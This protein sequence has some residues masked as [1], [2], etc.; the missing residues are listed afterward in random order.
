[1][2]GIFNFF[3]RRAEP[4]VEPRNYSSVYLVLSGLLFLGTMWALVD[5]ISTR[6]PWKEFQESYFKLSEKKWHE[7]LDEATTGFD[8]ASYQQLKSE[9]NDVEGKLKSPE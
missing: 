1:M 4:P 6:R 5:E 8:S 2:K 7:K 3:S 9:L